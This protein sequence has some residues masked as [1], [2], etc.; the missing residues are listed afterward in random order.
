MVNVEDLRN[1]NRIT[2]FKK[3][4]LKKY[5]LEQ[6]QLIRPQFS[7]IADSFIEELEAEVKTSIKHKLTNK[8]TTSRTLR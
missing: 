1:I 2:L 5:I 6:T 4:T 3:R 7:R 8:T